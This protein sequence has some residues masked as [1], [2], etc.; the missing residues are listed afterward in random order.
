MPTTPVFESQR[1]V[2]LGMLPQTD[3]ATAV[4]DT[5]PS[6]FFQVQVTDKNFGKITPTS[7]NNEEDAHGIDWA[8]EEYL[9]TWN[10]E[11]QHDVAVSSERV[12]RLLLLLFGSVTTTQPAVSTDPTVFQHVFT[13]QNAD[14]SRQLPAATI[15]E[16][17]S[18]ALNRLYQS[19]VMESFTMKGDG[20]KRVEASFDMTGSGKTKEGSAVTA[21]Q[22][23]ALMDL[24]GTLHYFFNQQAV[25][26]VAD[27]GGGSPVDYGAT[28]RL[29]SW[30]WSWKNNLLGEEG[31]RPGSGDFLTAGD[32]TS[33]SIRSEL[34]F[35]KRE[36]AVSFVTRFLSQSDEYAALKARK[37]LDLKFVLTGKIISH[38]FAHSLTIQFPR[39][40]YDTVELGQSNGI[41]TAAVSSNPRYDRA[42]SKIVTATLVNTVTSYTS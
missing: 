7:S 35:G 19:L 33:G 29:N 39:A 20:Q 17:V 36:P 2:L 30:E 11:V 32:P 41:I 22:G 40:I 9:E 31:Y 21:A 15:I 25:L 4:D 16:I 8:T 28:K 5:D 38:A 10:T 23:L 24:P 12:G 18:G 6:K 27:V 26:T 37:P 34:L 13:P 3:F 1:Q 42:T 14:T